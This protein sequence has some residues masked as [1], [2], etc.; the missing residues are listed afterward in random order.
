VRGRI[1]YERKSVREQTWSHPTTDNLELGSNLFLNI[2]IVEYEYEIWS[3][4]I[5]RWC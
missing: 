3:R 5:I 1:A 4:E 2:V